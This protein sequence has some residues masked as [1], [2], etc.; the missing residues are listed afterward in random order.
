[1]S[2]AKKELIRKILADTNSSQGR[3]GR[4]CLSRWN[5]AGDFKWNVSCNVGTCL[6][7]P[8]LVE[9]LKTK[10][11]KGAASSKCFLYMLFLGLFSSSSS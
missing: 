9:G 6:S 2:S 5:P 7:W 11:K 10:K 4:R 3:Q 8:L 1:M